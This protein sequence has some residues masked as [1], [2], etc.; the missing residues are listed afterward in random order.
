MAAELRV[1]Y[2]GL[3]ESERECAPL[4]PFDNHHDAVAAPLNRDRAIHGAAHRAP[5]TC[6]NT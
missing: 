2:R 3:I 6:V 1:Q 4:A 5:R